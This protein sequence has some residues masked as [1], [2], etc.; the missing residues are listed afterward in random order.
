MEM[1]RTISALLG[2]SRTEYIADRQGAALLQA[3]KQ[4]TGPQ[5][6][7]NL[8]TATDILRVLSAGDPTKN[9]QYL[10]WIANRYTKNDFSLEDVERVNNDL[11]DF[12]RVRNR[13]SNKDINSYTLDNLYKAMEPLLSAG[14]TASMKTMRRWEPTPHEQQMVDRGELRLIY[15]DD[16]VRI[17]TPLTYTAS[18][19]LGTG[20]KWCTSWTTNSTHFD[21][22]SKQ[23]P[24][25]IIHTPDGKFQF[26]FETQQFMNAQ[27]RSAELGALVD[28]YPQI[29]DVFK[30]LAEQHGVLGLLKNPTEPAMIAFV[31]KRP[32]RIKELQPSRLTQKVVD[33]A[34]DNV[35]KYHLQTVFGYIER[36][37]PDLMTPEVKLLAIKADPGAIKS[38]N[39][40]EVTS[41][42][43][44]AASK[45]KD[46]VAVTDVFEWAAKHVP[47]LLSEKIKENFLRA[48]G[49]LLLKVG[50]DPSQSL[51]AAALETEETPKAITALEHAMKN[52]PDKVT[53]KEL[54]NLVGRSQTALKFVPENRQTLEIVK[55]SL[56]HNLHSFIHVRK[57]SVDMIV[58]A[59]AEGIF[60]LRDNKYIRDIVT[61][62]MIK[63]VA[64][65]SPIGLLHELGGTV[66]DKEFL[67]P[68]IDKKQIIIHALS[69][70]GTGLKYVDKQTPEM[71]RVAVKNTPD[72]W[73]YADA[74]VVKDNT[75]LNKMYQQHQNSL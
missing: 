31:S 48:N 7:T 17:F 29:G 65:I 5:K 26:H 72:A 21:S 67:P 30:E 63:K 32:E 28:R 4:D 68:Q 25:Y 40:G 6:P 19:H 12:G 35:E 23:G 13:L 22:Y 53:D 61:N 37:R 16:Q 74:K 33:A 56:D 24:L 20:T 51:V 41:Q 18:C 73:K 57:P 69:F 75:V 71:I 42:E 62:D 15:G 10:Q 11:V 60:L 52:Y 14:E 50:K 38:I 59:L 55:K 54:L 3:Y 2:E 8:K 70:K 44:E 66:D 45:G 47:H 27:D 34:M 1:L 49:A 64:E 58:H 39:P 43:L 46:T 9:K 36:F